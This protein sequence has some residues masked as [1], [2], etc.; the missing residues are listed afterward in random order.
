[1]LVILKEYD[2]LE[3]IGECLSSIGHLDRD[4]VDFFRRRAQIFP[5]I[6]RE[7]K[8]PCIFSHKLVVT[9]TNTDAI[10]QGTDIPGG[11]NLV[12]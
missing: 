11:Y 4:S 6:N 5:M 10:L 3:S 7:Q 12:V 2:Q 8:T 1:L 9:D